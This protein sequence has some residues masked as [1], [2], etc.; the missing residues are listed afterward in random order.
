MIIRHA[1]KKIVSTEKQ[2]WVLDNLD[3][4]R[5][6]STYSCFSVLKDH[7]KLF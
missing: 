1:K 4:S 6:S 3:L 2:Q 7:S 5:L